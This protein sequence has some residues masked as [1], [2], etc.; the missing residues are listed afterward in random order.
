MESG[1]FSLLNFAAGIFNN[2]LTNEIYSGFET[3]P[4]VYEK[5]KYEFHDSSV[6]RLYMK[7]SLSSSLNQ[8][9]ENTIWSRISFAYC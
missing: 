5:E 3:Y 8:M 6:T 7:L 4:E 2:F 9:Q 1:F